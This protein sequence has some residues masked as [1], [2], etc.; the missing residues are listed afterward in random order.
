M[1]KIL[2]LFDVLIMIDHP[3]FVTT[4]SIEGGEYNINLKS[5]NDSIIGQSATTVLLQIKSKQLTYYQWQVNT[6]SL[7]HFIKLPLLQLLLT[8]I[9]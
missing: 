4:N 9:K 2:L 8:L 1:R 7:S 3:S 5:I 6:H